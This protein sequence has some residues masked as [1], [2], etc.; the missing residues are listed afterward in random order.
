LTQQEEC[1]SPSPVL[2]FGKKD[3]E[4]KERKGKR[5]QS[6]QGLWGARQRTQFPFH[7]GCQMAI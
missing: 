3:N 7:R 4:E 5:K 2:V 1:L 6:G